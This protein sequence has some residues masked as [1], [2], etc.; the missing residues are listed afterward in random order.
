MMG[1]GT[2]LVVPAAVL[3]V[4]CPGEAWAGSTSATVDVTASVPA[5]CAIST[6]FLAFSAYDPVVT[7]ASVPDDA[8]GSIVVRCTKGATGISI[9]LGSGLHNSGGQRQLVNGSTGVILLPYE[10]YKDGNRTSVWGL[11]DNGAINALADGTG[12]EVTVTMYGRIPPGQIQAI[13]GTYTDTLVSTIN[14]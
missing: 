7:N 10:V 13:S 9:D 2:A 4:V 14:F 11:G 6:A 5:S 12:A 1:R 3:L 8:T